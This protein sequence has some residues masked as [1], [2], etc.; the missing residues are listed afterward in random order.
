MNGRACAHIWTSP[1]VS[2]RLTDELRSR[3]ATQTTVFA[4]AFQVGLERGDLVEIGGV[5][6][7]LRIEVD[8]EV[9]LALAVCGRVCRY[10]AVRLFR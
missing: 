10:S 9:A 2:F 5:V 4:G 6:V 8:D 1:T 7:L 3:S